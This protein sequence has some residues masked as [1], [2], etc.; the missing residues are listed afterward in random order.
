LS[1]TEAEIGAAVT[2]VAKSNRINVY[3][4][5]PAVNSESFRTPLVPKY[6][7]MMSVAMKTTGQGI[8]PILIIKGPLPKKGP[9]A[10]SLD[11]INS[12][13]TA[14]VIKKPAKTIKTMSFLELNSMVLSSR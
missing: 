5:K 8:I 11:P 14:L 12:A 2:R 6:S 9:R 1:V 4:I 3:E 13:T 10:I 7:L